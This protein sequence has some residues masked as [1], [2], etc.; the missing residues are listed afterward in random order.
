M[1]F[2]HFNGRVTLHCSN[3]VR[4]IDDRMSGECAVV[5]RSR[6]RTKF[7]RTVLPRTLVHVSEG[8]AIRSQ[9]K[10]A[11]EKKAAACPQSL[12]QILNTGG[13]S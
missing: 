11:Q 12:N 5:Q 4:L 2:S 6:C 7:V 8:T 3:W 1:Q 13:K 9:K 10:A